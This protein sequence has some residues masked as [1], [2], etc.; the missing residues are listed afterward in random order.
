MAVYVED[1]FIVANNIDTVLEVNELMKEKFSIKDLGP[2]KHV[3][4]SEKDNSEDRNRF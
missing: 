4:G 2:V 1:I 3:F